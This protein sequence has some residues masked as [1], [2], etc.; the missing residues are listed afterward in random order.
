VLMS[1]SPSTGGRGPGTLILHFLYPGM[2]D[3]TAT[4][5]GC[6]HFLRKWK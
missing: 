2:A 4:L 5:A 6:S 3:S 1:L